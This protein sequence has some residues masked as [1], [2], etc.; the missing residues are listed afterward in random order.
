MYA[1]A[2]QSECRPEASGSGATQAIRA[3][4]HIDVVCGLHGGKSVRG[5][6]REEGSLRVRFPREYGPSLTGVI[7]NTGGGMTGGDRFAIAAEAQA[8]ARLTLT[9]SAAEKF[10]RSLGET[11]H[12]EVILCARAGSS[13][14]WLPQEAILFDVAKVRR[15]Y[16]IHGYGDAS[17]LLCDLN[18]IGRLAMGE[19]VTDLQAF[20]R[21]R[22][23][24]DGKLRYADFARIAG[25]PGILLSGPAATAGAMS[26]GTLVLCSAKAEES[27]WSLRSV[28]ADIQGVECAAGLVNGICAARFVAPDIARLRAAMS[29]C[30]TTV[31]GE[32]L[33]RSWAT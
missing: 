7:V 12:V 32:A 19:C 11:A 31:S 3:R 25:D 1:S 17:V 8:G 9:T 4:G 26:F 27:C 10:Y 29:V 18:C 20:D 13:L 23:W 15:T 5:R 24:W 28:M 2:L 33:P 30:I 6:V 21:W 22:I 16:D 14:A